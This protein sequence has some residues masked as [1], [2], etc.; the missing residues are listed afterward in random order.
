M[1]WVQE[2]N[3]TPLSN[4]IA[5]WRMHGRVTVVRLH[6]HWRV[7]DLELAIVHANYAHG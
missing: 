7:R 1:K 5:H 4:A 2:G 3:I 6:V